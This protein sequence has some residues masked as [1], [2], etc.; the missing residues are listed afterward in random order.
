MPL[1][2]EQQKL[3]GPEKAGWEAGHISKHVA[4]QGFLD[5]CCLVRSTNP[6]QP[7]NAGVLR[8]PKEEHPAPP[9]LGAFG[10]RHHPTSPPCH[11]LM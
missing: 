1:T 11:L 4:P 9:P 6:H 3:P 7:K 2:S 10:Q 5:P 8:G